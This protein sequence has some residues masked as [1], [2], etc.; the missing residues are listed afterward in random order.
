M[1]PF[2]SDIYDINLPIQQSHQIGDCWLLSAVYALSQSSTGLEILKEAVSDNYSETTVKFKGLDI[3]ISIDNDE[4]TQAMKNNK[5]SSGSKSFIIFELAFE[6]LREKISRGEV[7]LPEEKPYYMRN[8]F[9]IFKNKLSGGR[10][11]EAFFYLTG[12]IVHYISSRDYEGFAKFEESND[13]VSCCAFD[14]DEDFPVVDYY[15]N[16]INLFS[17]HA[18]SIKTVDKNFVSI[19]NP[20]NTDVEIFLDR[21]DFYTFLKAIEY[22]EL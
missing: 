6:K 20:H 1:N 9:R 19:V 8:K 10:P 15:G 5:Y 11:A 17:G 3:I 2:E 16:K 13:I 21:L 7:V 14:V 12:N 4:I 18:Y 22:C